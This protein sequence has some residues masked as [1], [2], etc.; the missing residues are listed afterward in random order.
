[1]LDKEQMTA[2]L[3]ASKE[4]HLAFIDVA[5]DGLAMRE[6]RQTPDL[7][8][9]ISQFWLHIL[10]LDMPALSNPFDAPCLCSMPR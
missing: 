1:M 6:T 10:S 8:L 5:E 2:A 3:Q 4:Q 9:T 7:V